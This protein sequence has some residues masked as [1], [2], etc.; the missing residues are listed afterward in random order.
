MGT[1]WST[2]GRNYFVRLRRSKRRP[3]C[4]TL[5]TDRRGRAEAIGIKRRVRR[6]SGDEVKANRPQGRGLGIVIETVIV[7][8]RAGDGDPIHQIKNETPGGGVS[9]GT[10]ARGAD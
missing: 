1:R 9:L 5:L 10:G 4:P 8:R 2:T 3:R 7:T 6:R